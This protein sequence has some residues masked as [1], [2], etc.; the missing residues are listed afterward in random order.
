MAKEFHPLLLII[1]LSFLIS[2]TLF[3]VSLTT[4]ADDSDED[5]SPADAFRAL[6]PND[7]LVVTIA[8]FAVEENNM[9]KK[10]NIEFANVL[11]AASQQIGAKTEYGLLIKADENGTSNTYVAVVLDSKN[12][13]RELVGFTKPNLAV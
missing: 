2:S 1:F 3:D 11:K 8:K 9:Q 12:S 13:G 10:E 6:D 5:F 7:P 4:A